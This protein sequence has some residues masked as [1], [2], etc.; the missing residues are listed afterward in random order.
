MFCK[1]IVYYLCTL[2]GL[3]ANVES[4]LLLQDM[5]PPMLES[6]GLSPDV[7]G[8]IVTAIDE[9]SPITKELKRG[10]VII[11]VEGN[12]NYDLRELIAAI[13]T[14]R[15]EEIKLTVWRDQGEK[16]IVIYPMQQKQ[17]SGDILGGAEFANSKRGV[18]VSRP[19]KTGLFEKDDLILEFNGNPVKQA[20]D[21]SNTIA[22]QSNAFSVVVN[23]KGIQV[24]LALKVDEYGNSSFS[25]RFNF[26][27]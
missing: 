24:D 27:G 23:R 25:Q 4:S 18:V 13:R 8:V 9:N 12:I 1:A 22:K 19:G 16:N 6:V 26:K 11:A 2:W 17:V 5:T 21:I 10:D 3:F 15:I 7:H 14:A 20:E